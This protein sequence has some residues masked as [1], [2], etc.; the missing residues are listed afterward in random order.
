MT[1]EFGYWTRH[2]PLNININKPGTRNRRALSAQEF[3]SAR[4]SGAFPAR[5]PRPDR[6]SSPPDVAPVSRG[7]FRRLNNSFFTRR[8][9]LGSP[10]VG[11]LATSS[12]RL[13]NRSTSRGTRRISTDPSTSPDP[14]ER[15]EEGTRK[16][17]AKKRADEE[18]ETE[19]Q[20]ERERETDNKC[21][22]HPT[23]SGY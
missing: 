19:R 5:L 3:K 9:N 15:A 12:N 6:P 20:G 21:N 22:S 4:E 11:T 10:R 8:S 16:R 18:R 2:R 7:I 17:H 14:S 13:P 23:R 1:A